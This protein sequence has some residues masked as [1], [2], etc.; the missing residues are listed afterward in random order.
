MIKTFREY[1]SNNS[2]IDGLLSQLIKLTWERYNPE[3]RDFFD[4]ISSKDADIRQLIQQLDSAMTPAE[5]PDVV[6]KNASDSN[7]GN[8][9][10]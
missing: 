3:I 9:E 2:N 8:G 7:F 5:D 1:I 6:S 10:L 4:K